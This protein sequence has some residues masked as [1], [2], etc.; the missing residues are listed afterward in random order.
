M[1][2]RMGPFCFCGSVDDAG[3]EKSENLD[4]TPGSHVIGVGNALHVLHRVRSY[5]SYTRHTFT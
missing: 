5:V 3:V 1:R 2:E 4:M